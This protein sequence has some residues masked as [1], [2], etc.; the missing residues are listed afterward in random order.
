[1]A[2]ERQRQ[3]AAIQLLLRIEG[4]DHSGDVTIQRLEA[5]FAFEPANNFARRVD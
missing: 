1:M 2:F 3:R 5:A 4:G